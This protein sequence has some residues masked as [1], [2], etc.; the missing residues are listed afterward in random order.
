M[1]MQNKYYRLA[2]VV[3]EIICREPMEEAEGLKAFQISQGESDYQIYIENA[4]ETEVTPDCHG[5][6]AMNR[7]ETRISLRINRRKLKKLSDWQVFVM[8]PLVSLLLEKGILVLHASH[9]HHEGKAIL[10]TGD[11]GVGKSTQADLWEKYRN[12]EIINGDRTLLYLRDGKAYA[13]GHFHCGT[14]GIRKNKTAPI[15]GVVLL[16]QGTKNQVTNPGYLVLFQR[17]LSQ[18]AYDVKRSEDV[19]M[20]TALVADMINTVKMIEYH[21][22]KDYSAVEELERYL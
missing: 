13:A 22:R 14:S 19:K 11:C 21:C 8:L 7:Q 10:F 6:A 18:C 1:T 17:I 4:L 2:D 5:Y 3:F 15:K 20:A 9:I 12:A 16:G